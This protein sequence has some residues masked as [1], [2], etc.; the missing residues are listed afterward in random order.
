VVV[1]FLVS[2]RLSQREIVSCAIVNALDHSIARSLCRSSSDELLSRCYQLLG[3]C[4]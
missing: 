4:A 1:A 2:M 3:S